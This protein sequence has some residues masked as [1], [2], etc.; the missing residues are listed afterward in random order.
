MD[1]AF[2][3]ADGLLPRRVIAE[4]DVDMGIDQA[5]HGHHAAGIDRHL[6]IGSIAAGADR[7]DLAVVEDD[8]VARRDGRGDV[9]GENF[10]DIEDRN[11]HGRRRPLRRI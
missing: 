8:G 4:R 11:F 6:A 3:E 10:R 1:V 9:A 2:E 7:N 5:G